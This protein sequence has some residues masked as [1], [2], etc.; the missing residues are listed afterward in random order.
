[1][2]NLSEFQLATIGWGWIIIL[3]ILVAVVFFVVVKN[4][5]RKRHRTARSAM[6]K[7]N[8]VYINGFYRGNPIGTEVKKFDL[9]FLN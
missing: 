4:M 5:T 3:I 9:H 7:C 2:N 1:M 8:D 6:G